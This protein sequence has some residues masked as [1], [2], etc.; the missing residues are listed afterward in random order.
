M[1]KLDSC[2]KRIFRLRYQFKLM[3]YR[4][5]SLKDTQALDQRTG[6]VLKYAGIF[7]HVYK[8]NTKRKKPFF[9]FVEEMFAAF[10]PVDALVT[11]RGARIQALMVLQQVKGKKKTRSYYIYSKQ[12]YI[13]KKNIGRMVVDSLSR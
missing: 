7:E 13:V 9:N 12:G 10:Q 3:N 5:T 8:G 11:T 6:S 1:S 4:S 2:S